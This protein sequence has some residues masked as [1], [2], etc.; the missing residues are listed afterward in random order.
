[1]EA[2][3]PEDGS[4]ENSLSPLIRSPRCGFVGLSDVNALLGYI[5][6]IP[7]W[8]YF[9]IGAEGRREAKGWNRNRRL[10]NVA[11]EEVHENAANF[12][13]TLD[14]FLWNVSGRCQGQLGKW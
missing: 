1:M 5:W 2:W 11:A 13:K 10:C 3:P 14:A 12:K 4:R 6:L 7:T 9:I 8:G